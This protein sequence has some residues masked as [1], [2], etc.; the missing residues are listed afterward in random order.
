MAQWLQPPVTHLENPSSIPR[1]D[2]FHFP[3]YKS[4]VQRQW[5]HK[6]LWSWLRTSRLGVWV[7]LPLAW[8]TCLRISFD[9]LKFLWKTCEW[10]KGSIIWSIL[11]C[12]GSSNIGGWGLV[13][14]ERKSE[15]L[16]TVTLKI[17]L[18]IQP[19][20]LLVT[21]QQKFQK[22]LLVLPKNCFLGR[23]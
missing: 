2:N 16:T 1:V 3:F 5:K 7:Q 4:C 20:I 13:G 23:W 6:N 21:Q 10:E 9:I 22:I 11:S 14:W 15:N 19:N 18:M 8:N 17:M 12:G